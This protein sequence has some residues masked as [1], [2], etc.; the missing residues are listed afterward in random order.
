M[1][2]ALKK[3]LIRLLRD[4]AGESY[5]MAGG[6]EGAWIDKYNYVGDLLSQA[7]TVLEEEL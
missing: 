6:S 2:L 3:E 5:T 1:I 7:A 4:E